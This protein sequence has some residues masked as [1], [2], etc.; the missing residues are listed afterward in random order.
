MTDPAQQGKAPS[1]ESP[2][3]NDER[4]L[5]QDPADKRTRDLQLPDGIKLQT[6]AM[7]AGPPPAELPNAPLSRIGEHE[8]LSEIGRGGMGVVFKA[9]HVRLHRVVALKMILGGLLARPEDLQRFETEA[10]AAAQLQHPNIV[11]LYEVGTHDGQPYFSMEYISGSSLAQRVPL[12][13]LPGRLAASYLERLARAVHY[14]HGRGVIHRDLKPANVLLDDTDQPKITDFGLAK[15]LQGNSGQTRSGAILGTPSYMAPE[16]AGGKSKQIGPATDVYGL[17]AI[18]YECLTGLPPFRG[19]TPMDTVLQVMESDPVPPRLLNPK[20]DADLETICLKCLEKD[21]AQRYDSGEELADDLRRFLD[22]EPIAA[23]RL[24][25]LRRAVK[26]CRRRPAVAALLLVSALALVGFSVFQWR[27]AQGERRLRSEADRQRNLAQVREKAMRH[28]HYLA[29]MRHVQHVWA[30][31]DLD[32]AER[33]LEEWAPAKGQPDLR[34][35]EWFYL[36]GLCQGRATLSAYRGRATSVAF[37]PD[38]KRLATAG[39]QPGRA[40]EVKIW[41]VST[42]RLVRTLPPGPTKLVGC[43]TY[44]PDGTYLATADDEGKVRLWHVA[45][46]KELA[47]LTGH[48]AHV[49][50]VAFSADGRRLASADGDGM[51]LVWDVTKALAGKGEP[52]LFILR[53]HGGEV[54]G[55][56][57]SPDGLLLASSGFDETVRLWD[58]AA[59]KI[60]HTLRGHEGEVMSVAFSPTGKFL[61]SG[62]GPGLHRGQVRFWDPAS[63]KMLKVRHGLS[64]RVLAVAVSRKGQVAA[65]AGDGLIHIWDE[66]LSSEPVV[67]RADVHIV[68]GIAFDPAGNRLASAGGDGRV[69][70]WHP[71]GGQETLRL[72]GPAL[73]EGAAFTPDGKSV[74]SWG[75]DPGQDGTAVV[76]RLDTGEQRARLH[77]HK[78][79]VRALA[80]SRDGNQAATGGDDQTVRLY[81]LASPDQAR[82]LSG[83]DGRVLALAFS[84]KEDLLASAGEGDVIHL[85]DTGSG[86]EVRT[87]AKA[88]NDVLTLAFSP[89]GRWLASGGYDKKVRIWNMVEGTHIILEGHAGTVNTIAFSPAGEQLASGGADKAVIIWDWKS[90]QEFLRLKELGQA[91]VSL[92][93]Q[94]RGQRLATVGNDR[95]IRLW[96]LV[97]GQQILELSGPEGGLRG[98]AFSPDGRFLAAAG[99]NTGLRVWEAPGMPGGT[100]GSRQ[101]AQ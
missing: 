37:S 44:S 67:L 57:F 86:K 6:G 83:H 89:D 74:A 32:A 17:G 62:G 95:A 97:P 58:L 66:R 94:P 16:Q 11:A 23:R 48:K 12:G 96:D 45:T 46:G 4:T 73:A 15:L 34:G 27:V 14:A 8:L 93:Y 51:V 19:E 43:V 60:Q 29:Q 36:K 7:G 70:L 79:S 26:W 13:V 71:D 76:W 22:G 25:A 88:G 5:V 75:R 1:S 2:P 77:G 50:S 81:D 59:G 18:L 72:A 85:W 69:R 80:F 91:V 49:S 98:V 78:G 33:L 9:R 84:P 87:L 39:G 92:A 99:H 10:A 30:S 61:V 63:G 31:A 55:V 40:G 24:G 100:L 42:S 41:E 21:P 65:A 101:H 68:Y 47:C 52:R 38:G 28:L 82:V 56:T 20:I 53:G 54:T 3:P 64:A 90:G 35:W